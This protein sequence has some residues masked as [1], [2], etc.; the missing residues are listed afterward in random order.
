MKKFNKYLYDN[1][2]RQ[3]DR[4][5]LYLYEVSVLQEKIETT[6]GKE[7]EELEKKLKNLIK[8]KNDHP[9]NKK[10]ADYKQ[11]EK[12]FI[13]NTKKKI[14]KNR[15]NIIDKSLPKKVQKL[16]E[17]LFRAKEYKE[18]YKNYVDLTYDA[19]LIC[20]QS[21]MEIAQIPPVVEFAQ[22]CMKELKAAEVNLTKFKSVDNESF[23]KEFKKYKHQ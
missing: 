14:D 19:E 18:F 8:G 6:A 23:N 12:E 13:S 7:R 11:K 22:D 10:L 16:Q 20:K 15:S 21:N 9:Y 17:R 3:Y 1:I 5:N 4:K 2:N